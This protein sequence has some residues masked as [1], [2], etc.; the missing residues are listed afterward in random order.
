LNV[1]EDYKRILNS[2]RS[3]DEP[4]LWEWIEEEGEEEEEG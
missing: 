1:E 3:Q 4:E 2:L